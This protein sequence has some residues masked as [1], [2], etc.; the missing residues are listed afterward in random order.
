M[1]TTPVSGL[2]ISSQEFWH[3][4]PRQRDHTFA[5]LRRDQPISFHPPPAVAIAQP[6]GLTEPRGFW[7]VVRHADVQHV[8]RHPDLFSSAKGVGFEDLP[9]DLSEQVSSIVAMD[10]P[11]HDTLR[12]LISSAFTPRNVA[13]IETQIAQQA[14]IIVDELLDTGDCDFVTQVAARLPMWTISEMIGI[15]SADRERISHAADLVIGASDEELRDG[16]ERLTSTLNAIITLHAAATDLAGQRR[17]NPADDLMT[18]LVTAEID[19]ERLTDADI[20]SFFSLLCI[21]GNDTTRHTT[22]HGMFALSQHPDQRARWASDLPGLL[23]TAVEELLRWGSVVIEFAR[24]A[25]ADV[26][27][28]GHTIRAGDRVVMFYESANHDEAVFVD[29]WDFDIAREPNRHLAFGG[30]GLHYCLGSHIARTQ[31]RCL[32][33]ELLSRGQQIDIGEPIYLESVFMNAL[34]HLP[35]T[36]R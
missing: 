14:R 25:T 24:I 3:Q 29:P 28:H 9:Q 30:G 13:K 26:D 23:E 7:A 2:D 20:A 6:L 5:V 27:L 36:I 11:R 22:A 34:K 12:R 16:E 35:C 17:D 19:G 33:T 32:F 10:P 18:A 21:A 4:T 1:T 15:D 31:L 8:S